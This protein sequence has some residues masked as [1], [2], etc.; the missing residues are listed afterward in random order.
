MK[1]LE[2]LSQGMKKYQIYKCSLIFHTTKA[3]YKSFQTQKIIKR[4]NYFRVAISE[5]V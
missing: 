2:Y 1:V 3:F 4:I 5:N